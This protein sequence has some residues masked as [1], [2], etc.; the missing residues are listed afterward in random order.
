VIPLIFFKKILRRLF[1]IIG[2]IVHSK[3]G[4][5]YSVAEKVNEKLIKKGHLVTIERIE[6]LGGE[7][8][9]ERDINN[10]E[11]DK[12]PDLSNYDAVIFGGPVRGFS[13][14][15]VLSAYITQVPSLKNKKVGL[16]V[17]EQFPFPWMGGNHAIS[18][19]KRICESRGAEI[20]AEGIVNWSNK[21]REAMINETAEKLS[22]L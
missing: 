14:S 2:I 1:M 12:R 3:T 6:P 22:K 18:Q 9:N 15:L 10:I 16:L 19:M 13:M 8:V 20:Y 5:T 21:K 7:N 17:T 11:F 4:N